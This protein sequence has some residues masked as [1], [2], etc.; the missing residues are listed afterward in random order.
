M[1][2]NYVVENCFLDIIILVVA[3]VGLIGA[4]LSGV[5]GGIVDLLD[6]AAEYI[7]RKVG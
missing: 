7:R 1:I 6:R 4:I 5:C 3:L 2:W